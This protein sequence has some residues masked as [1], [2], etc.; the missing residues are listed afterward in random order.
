MKKLV[1]TLLAAALSL[2]IAFAQAP[3][4][5]D[6]DKPAK[7]SAKKKVHKAKKAPKSDTA[8]PAAK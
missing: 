2:P 8:A 3:A 6:T 7:K 4:A 5:S 1:I